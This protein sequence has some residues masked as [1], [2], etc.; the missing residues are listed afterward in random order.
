MMNSECL[1]YDFMVQAMEVAPI[2]TVF[3]DSEGALS[4]S[5]RLLARC[6]DMRRKNVCIIPITIGFIRRT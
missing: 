5:I 4:K 2:G 1:S 3:I 6:S